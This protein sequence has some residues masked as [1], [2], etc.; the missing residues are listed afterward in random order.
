[1]DT[2]KSYP[3]QDVDYIKA[4]KV[5]LSSIYGMMAQ[6]VVSVQ[7]GVPDQKLLTLNSNPAIMDYAGRA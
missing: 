4:K 3:N 7:D 5:Q 6:E 2:N 1:M